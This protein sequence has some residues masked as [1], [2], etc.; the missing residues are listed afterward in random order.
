M[1]GWWHNTKNNEFLGSGGKTAMDISVQNQTEFCCSVVMTDN[2]TASILSD[3]PASI[4][5][6]MPLILSVGDVV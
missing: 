4:L 3:I 2:A 1:H 6:L 5:L